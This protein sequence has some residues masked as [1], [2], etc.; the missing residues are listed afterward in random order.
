M[1][2]LPPEFESLNRT[3]NKYV[4]CSAMQ[5]L[6]FKIENLNRILQFNSS[7]KECSE[8]FKCNI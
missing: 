6:P 7:M 8:Y 1:Q 3:L 4:A 2:C 5:C